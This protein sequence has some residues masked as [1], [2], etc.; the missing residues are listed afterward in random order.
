LDL[1][2]IHFF[3]SR[4]PLRTLEHLL[5]ESFQLDPCDVVVDLISGVLDPVVLLAEINLFLQRKD[6][7][8]QPIG[9]HADPGQA[10]SLELTDL[11]CQCL[12]R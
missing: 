5:Q 12:H 6:S 3:G 9:D 8:S 10:E 4:L 11:V 7:V 2:C 1:I